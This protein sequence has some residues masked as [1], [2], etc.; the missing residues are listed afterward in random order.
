MGDE[1]VCPAVTIGIRPNRARYQTHGFQT[2]RQLSGHINQLPVV[3]A[4]QKLRGS[5]RPAAGDDSRTDEKI[6]IAVA[7]KV[8]SRN[9]AP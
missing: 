8:A 3:V 1:Q 5:Q 2:W 6:Q 9:T 7:V 4:Q